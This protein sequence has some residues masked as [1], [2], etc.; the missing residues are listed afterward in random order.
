[1]TRGAIHDSVYRMLWY[2]AG[3]Y[4]R[5]SASVG[6]TVVYWDVRVVRNT[7]VVSCWAPCAI[8]RSRRAH[9]HGEGSCSVPF[10]LGSL[11]HRR[12]FLYLI[13]T[14]AGVLW[15]LLCKVLFL[16][17]SHADPC[18][19]CKGMRHESYIPAQLGHLLAHCGKQQLATS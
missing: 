14:T 1:M 16:M 13:V 8:R 18:L 2:T 12:I 10:G 7:M 4:W 11:V 15:H 3:Y 6:F 19:C 17:L 9:R 5:T